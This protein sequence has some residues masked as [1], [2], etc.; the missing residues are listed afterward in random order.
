MTGEELR[1]ARDIIGR[2]LG[3][4][5]AI[6]AVEIGRALGLRGD[7]PGES[8]RGWERRGSMPGPPAEAIRG[9]VQI[10]DLGGTPPSLK[11][12]IVRRASEAE[13]DPR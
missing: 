3:L 7:D 4:D 2:R 1:E 9:W 11:Q 10:T 13:D 8:V 5:R 6:R 12:A